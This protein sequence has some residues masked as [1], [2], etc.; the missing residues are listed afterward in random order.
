MR[1]KQLLCLAMIDRALLD[2]H[3]PTERA[4]A[5]AATARPANARSLPMAL[6]KRR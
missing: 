1:P 6:S 4:D 2:L 5:M 3:L